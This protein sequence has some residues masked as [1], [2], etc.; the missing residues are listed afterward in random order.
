MNVI[1]IISD[2][3]RRDCVGCYGAP[4]WAADFKTQIGRIHTPHLDR[5]ARQALVFDNA[6]IASFPTVPARNDLLTGRYTW[7]YKPWAPLDDEITLPGV[8][9]QAGVLTALVADTP[10]PFAPGYNY[11]RDFHTWELVRGQENDRWRADPLAVEWPAAR[12]KLRN[13]DST[14]VQYLRNTSDRRREEDYFPARTFRRAARWLERNYEREPFYLHV[15]TFDPHEPWDPPPYY[16]DRYDPN[17]E[18]EKVIYPRYD[19]CHYLSEAELN[20][21]RAL[22]AGEVTM[23]D[24]WFGYFLNRIEALGLL[25]NT[26]IIFTS[27]HG[28]YL[29]EHGYV[30]KLII[31]EGVQQSIP[32]YPEVA[33]VPLL[34]YQPPEMAGRATAGTGHRRSSA[35]VQMVDLMPTICELLGAPL[36][37]SVQGQSFAPLLRGRA[38]LAKEFVICSPSL[39]YP[40]LVAPHPTTRASLYEDEWLLVYGAQMEKVADAET[41][42]TVDSLQRRV[43]TL[44]DEPV[45]PE[46]YHL[47]QE[48]AATRNLYGERRDVAAAMQARFVDFLE[49]HDVPERHLR[50]FRTL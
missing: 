7:T 16:T 32:L 5:F 33:R 15:D 9:D 20:H 37:A 29:G 21:C 30:G 8:L 50:Y 13:P 47:G 10:H 25:S 35:W 12:H 1:S 36:P 18:G 39:S 27:D 11:Q 17:Y 6:F 40:D 28:F 2:S 41:S 48:P 24:R 31:R 43:K 3:L 23:V 22:Y 44:E 49:Q 14:V 38:Q 45:A 19:R 46:L 34:I 4:P 42:S 26:V